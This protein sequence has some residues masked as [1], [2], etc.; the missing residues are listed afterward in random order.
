MIRLAQQRVQVS[1]DS[2]ADDWA[3]RLRNRLLVLAAAATGNIYQRDEVNEALA[4]EIEAV[5]ELLP[6]ERQMERALL[7]DT[8]TD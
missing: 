1:T 4:F 2:K 7:P 3:L 6:D 5:L 8:P